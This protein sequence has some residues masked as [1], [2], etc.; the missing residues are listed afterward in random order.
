MSLE[1]SAYDRLKAAKAPDESFSELVHRILADPKPSFRQLAGSLSSAE[2]EEVR[3]AV[4]RM[5]DL[6]APAEVRRT[7]AWRK[8]RGSRSRH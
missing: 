1:E 2:A 3:A 5:R 8:R 6:E 7:N 4:R